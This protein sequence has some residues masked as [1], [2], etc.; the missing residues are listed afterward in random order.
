MIKVELINKDEI[1]DYYKKHGEFACVCY[2]TPLEKAEVV[3]KHCVNAKHFSGGRCEYFKF[4]IEGV[5]RA[6]TA[7]L[8]RHSIGVTINEKSMRYCDFSSADIVVPPL[9]ERDTYAKKIFEETIENNK[10]AY[11]QLQEYFLEKGHKKETVNQDVR[12]LLPIGVET[13]GTW[14]FTLEAL[15]NLMHK[16]LCVRSQWEIRQLVM[17]MKQRVLEI[18]P[19][20]EELL[21]P[22]CQYLMWCPEGK[23]SCGYKPTKKE[24][25]EKLNSFNNK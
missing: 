7:Q 23:Q 19:E 1:K 21:V 3:G 17:L 9:I 2:N 16:R 10:K 15:I 20:L 13:S 8:N 11:E 24:L 14:G 22:N 12:Y 5:S 18:L 4:R 6:L 25:Q